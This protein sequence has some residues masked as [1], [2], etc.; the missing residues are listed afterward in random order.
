RRRPAASRP[1]R[2]RRAGAR[3]RRRRWR[4]PSA[5]A[6]LREAALAR[7][8][9]WRPL[10]VALQQI[11]TDDELLHLARAFVDAQRPDFAVEPLDRLAA[12]HAAAAPQLHRG[13]DDLLRAF[14]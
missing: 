3:A 6:S 1:G 7:A 12:L 11:A 8:R 5:A 14:G 2:R 10:L 13:V 9:S 4:S